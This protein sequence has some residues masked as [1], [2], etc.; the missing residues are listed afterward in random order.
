VISEAEKD[1]KNL[2]KII[3]LLAN[4]NKKPF[5]VHFVGN[6]VLDVPKIDLLTGAGG[7]TPSLHIVSCYIYFTAWAVE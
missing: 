5:H 6:G 4:V 3:L 2:K 7:E 1:E